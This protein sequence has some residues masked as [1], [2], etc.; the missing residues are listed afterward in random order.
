MSQNKTPATLRRRGPWISIVPRFDRS[1]LWPQIKWAF[2]T[3][4]FF[5]SAFAKSVGK[6]SDDLR[7]GK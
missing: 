4:D 2:W 1:G 3:W 6:Y 7:D 5:P